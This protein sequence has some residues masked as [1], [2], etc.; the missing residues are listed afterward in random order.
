MMSSETIVG[1]KRSGIDAPD[2]SDDDGSQLERGEEDEAA[3]PKLDQAER[4][5]NK[6]LLAQLSLRAGSGMETRKWVRNVGFATRT[7][8]GARQPDRSC[9]EREVRRGV[10]SLKT[11]ERKRPSTG[12]VALPAKAK[13]RL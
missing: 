4:Q 8:L 1:Y 3:G 5:R 2:T 11:S 12:R 13:R 6:G 7:I 9:A 10:R